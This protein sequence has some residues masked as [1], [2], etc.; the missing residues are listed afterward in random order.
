MTKTVN[1]KYNSKFFKEKLTEFKKPLQDFLGTLILID[2]KINFEKPTEL[3]FDEEPLNSGILSNCYDERALFEA[4]RG[5]SYAVFSELEGKAVDIFALRESLI[6]RG[7]M[8][9]NLQHLVLNLILQCRGA[10][11]FGAPTPFQALI[12]EEA[13][14]T[15]STVTDKMK[16]SLAVKNKDEVRLTIE[17]P[18]QTISKRGDIE[19]IGNFGCEISITTNAIYFNKMTYSKTSDSEI[20]KQVFKCA[21]EDYSFWSE[22]WSQIKECFGVKEKR[23]EFEIEVPSANARC[24]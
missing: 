9:C 24:S 15:V 4:Q 18:I 13:G 3:V 14:L 5:E 11:Q 23:P 17:A 19:E 2:N 20:A 12:S 8:D 10:I 22:L 7:V 6:Q 21:S 1:L 16:T